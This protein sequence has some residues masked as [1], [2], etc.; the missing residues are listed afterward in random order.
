MATAAGSLGKA[1]VPVNAYL[2]FNLDLAPAT[3][4]KNGRDVVVHVKP[5]GIRLVVE[6]DDGTALL[7]MT[8]DAEGI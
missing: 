2:E 6:T 5:A 7:S 4:S 8:I 3:T 1:R